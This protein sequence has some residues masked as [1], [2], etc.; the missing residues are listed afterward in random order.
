MRNFLFLSF[1]LIGLNAL[2]AQQPWRLRGRVVEAN[3]E[4][5]IGATIA[6]DGVLRA[7]SDAGG[8]FVF[9]VPERPAELV[10][11]QI[12]Y[13]ARRIPLDSAGF[14]QRQLEIQIL[15]TPSSM[16]LPEVGVTGKAME[17]LFEEDYRSVLLDY[18][19]AGPDVLLLVEERRQ[20]WLRLVADNGRVLD[21][22]A[23]PAPATAL[24][25]SCTGGMH[26]WGPEMA[27]EVTLAGR[28]LDTFPRYSAALFHDLV[29]PCVLEMGGHYVFRQMGPFRQSIQYYYYDPEQKV[30]PLAYVRDE[31]AEEQLLRRYREILAA[32]MRTLPD[33]DRD[34]ILDNKT[35][36]TDL[37]KVLDPE[38]LAKMAESNELVA[39]LGFF[40][41][42]AE[43]S[44]Y[45]PLF[46][47]DSTLLL[48]NH[49]NRT[50]HCFRLEP[51]RET[52]VP[53]DYHLTGG[54]KKEIIADEATQRFYARFS[55]GSEGLVLKEIDPTN[56]HLLKKYTPS[57]SPYL[58]TRYRMRSGY[59]YCIGQANAGDPNRRLYK[60]NIFKGGK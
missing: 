19:F 6:S 39:M 28:E 42:M 35:D 22:L 29:E 43:D 52:A 34:D 54:W 4:P 33:V 1:F 38:R 21:Q 7:V 55:G 32:Y 11:R 53:I 47:T 27:W 16:E 10:V 59:L 26:V 48:F 17:V 37:T 18:L 36:W 44:V 51:F 5:V 57:E 2:S 45:A 13:F 49:V 46:R 30:H 23:L 31:V 25:R 3:G 24:H 60:V 15:M 58:G 56:G 8:R 20:T 12:G 40:Q 9:E 50:L 14:L 41:L